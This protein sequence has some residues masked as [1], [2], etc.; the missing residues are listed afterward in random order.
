MGSK[1]VK[2]AVILVLTLLFL[3]N[4]SNST[5][6]TQHSSTY[7]HSFT[8]RCTVPS[9]GNL[10]ITHENGTLFNY[11]TFSYEELKNGSASRNVTITGFDNRPFY[12][13]LGYLDG[14]SFWEPIPPFVFYLVYFD[15]TPLN[16]N[17]KANETRHGQLIISV[18]GQPMYGSYAFELEP[19]DSVRGD[20]QP[21]D[22]G[23]DGKI[24]RTD[25]DFA[26]QEFRKTENW[27][28]ADYTLDFNRDRKI[29]MKEIGYL[30][31]HLAE[32]NLL[33]NIRSLNKLPFSET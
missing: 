3:G 25:L 24:D 9:I 23:G 14:G 10:T 20:V 18:T 5:L 22:T 4:A 33:V 28:L 26:V 32:S 19:F 1:E 8:V 27:T 30:A 7:E 13:S 15:S 21:L 29:D 11:T 2:I 6:G 17:F 12:V 16:P 31:R